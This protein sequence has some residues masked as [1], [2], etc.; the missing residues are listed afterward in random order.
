[1][2]YNITRSNGSTQTIADGSIDTSK[3]SIGVAGR[4]TLGYG[5]VSAETLIRMLENF[6]NS[7]APLQP[8]PGQLWYDT[9][10]GFMKYNTAST[11]GDNTWT[12]LVFADD[13]GNIGSDSAPWETIYANNLGSA[14]QDIDAIYANEIFANTIGSVASPVT[15]I[16]VDT[17]TNP[18]HATN[19]GYVDTNTVAIAGDTMTGHL[20]LNANPTNSLHAATK[21]YVDSIAAGLDV[22]DSCLVATTANITLSGT[23]TVDGVALSV[24]DRILVKD[25]TNP[26]DNGIYV[27]ASGAWARSDDTDGSP[28]NEVTSGMFTFVTSGT[29]NAATGWILTTSDPITVGTTALNFTQSSAAVDYIGGTGIDVTGNTISVTSDVVLTS[30]AQSIA[31]DKTFT[32]QIIAP[33]DGTN[34]NIKTT[35]TA[36]ETGLY[37]SSTQV[38]FIVN[39]SSKLISSTSSLIGTTGLT[40][41]RTNPDTVS[42]DTTL[43]LRAD[44]GG[45]SY[46]NMTPNGSTGGGR[47]LIGSAANAGAGLAYTSELASI[48]D[49]D[50]N[51][52]AFF[53][54]NGTTTPRWTAYNLVNSDSWVFRGD[55]EATSFS[56]SGGGDLVNT[57]S[58]QSVDGTKTFLD[59]VLVTGG[60]LANPG[61]AHSTD[62]DTGIMFNAGSV[63]LISNGNN[64]LEA[65]TSEITLNEDL[66]VTSGFTRVGSFN[67]S[68][69]NQLIVTNTSTS[70]GLGGGTVRVGSDNNS[71]GG[72]HFSGSSVSFGDKTD[73]YFTLFNY[74]GG[75][76]LWTARNPL[77]STGWEFRSQVS[78]PSFNSTS[79]LKYKKDVEEFTDALG[80]IK[81]IDVITYKRKT[82]DTD[83]KRY[84]GVTAES[85]AKVVPELVAFKDG[86]PDS[87]SYA[88]GFAL[89]TKAIQEQEA[90]FENADLAEYYAADNP[91]EPGTVLMIGGIAEVTACDNE[92]SMEVFGVVSTN[93]AF[94]INSSIAKD[95]N[96]VQVALAGRVPVKVIGKVKKGQRLVASAIIGVARAVD[97]TE[98]KNIST[99]SIIGRALEDKDAADVSSVMSVIGH[100]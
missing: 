16:F 71:G 4:N 80:K 11:D 56:L 64:V 62:V 60:S 98:L 7:T 85:L 25:Q 68:D 57:V 75:S 29:D 86:E 27:V 13:L 77:G 53:R 28:S 5:K 36:T 51:R 6:S 67:S 97:H 73:L 2:P 44:N 54:M 19:R 22:K 32:D 24:G 10:T 96:S 50:T 9:S 76:A 34:P 78:A 39:G 17:P 58:N 46:I 26:V 59:P 81:E 31:G 82:E 30:G 79:A 92:M 89:A 91:Y 20:T 69:H 45:I 74:V 12:R 52:L 63:R 43:R 95:H 55:V 88:H 93:P 21:Q 100:N 72:M 47:I 35:S 90:R 40:E 37:G 41:L 84:L 87:V 1:M 99:L 48:G 18:L 83:D 49:I 42:D 14:A 8:I 94:A 70:S 66:R 61:I 65:D 38:G 3:Y 15:E 23:Q 33:G